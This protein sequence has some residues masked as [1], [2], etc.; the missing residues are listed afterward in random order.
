VPGPEAPD[1]PDFPDVPG[2]PEDP[3]NSCMFFTNSLPNHY[4]N[5]PVA[6]GRFFCPYLCRRNVASKIKIKNKRIKQ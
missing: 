6:L 5:V 4:Q 1:Y 3:E 2:F